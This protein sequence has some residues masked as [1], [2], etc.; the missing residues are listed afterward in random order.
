M[1]VTAIPF[2]AP[3]AFD[4]PPH[5]ADAIRHAPRQAAAM[6]AIALLEQ[7]DAGEALAELA[8]LVHRIAVAQAVP[9]A[10]EGFDDGERIA[11]YANRFAPEAIQLLWQIAAQGRADLAI[12]MRWPCSRPTTSQCG[13]TNRT[14]TVRGAVH[15]FHR[16]PAAA[17]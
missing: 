17:P 10:A 1:P 13:T 12:A 8:G 7:V 14:E 16:R 15:H 11:A 2:K 4:I 3:A 9:Q 5:M 6:E